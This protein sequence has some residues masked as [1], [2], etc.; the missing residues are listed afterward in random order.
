MGYYTQY[1][2]E[3]LN[4]TEEQEK[5]IAL[6]LACCVFGCTAEE[7]AEQEKPVSVDFLLEDMYK[8]YDHEEDVRD[9]SKGYPD[10]GFIL[11]G[12]GEEYDDK[13]K[14]YVRDGVTQLAYATITYDP[15]SDELGFDYL[16]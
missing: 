2:M 16:R 5:E 10:I 6:K 12:D 1:S 4:A 15:P 3:L 13:W 14:L 7:L 8:W 11:S 9:I